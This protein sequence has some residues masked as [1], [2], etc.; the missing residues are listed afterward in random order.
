[1]GANSSERSRITR[2][3]LSGEIGIGGWVMLSDGRY[4][5]VKIE[6]RTH[7]AVDEPD[8]HDVR[9]TLHR[10]PVLGDR[11]VVTIVPPED[12]P[13]AAYSGDPADCTCHRHPSGTDP[14]C[15]YS[16]KLDSNL[17][18]SFEPHLRDHRGA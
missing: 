10:E 11:F 16:P 15:R 13:E 7:Y 8:T 4:Q 12:D 6:H 3:Y 9:L 2:E 5:I 1:M 14:L 18:L 17:D